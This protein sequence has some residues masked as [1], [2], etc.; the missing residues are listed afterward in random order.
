[1]MKS[2]MPHP[3][4]APRSIVVSLY[5]PTMAHLS[6]DELGSALS[7]ASLTPLPER[8]LSVRNVSL[9]Q[10][11]S[12]NN[13]KRKSDKPA[14]SKEDI[15]PSNKPAKSAAASAAA[16]PAPRVPVVRDDTGPLP[17]LAGNKNFEGCEK[18]GKYYITT[19]ISY[20]NGMPHIGHAYESLSMDVIA[21]WH[22]MYGRRVF[23]MTGTDEHGQKIANGAEAQGLQP[24]DICDK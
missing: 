21:R 3:I 18:R 14:S 11:S 10:V 24:I 5:F 20:S 1:M 17:E 22:R 6:Y 13:D 4:S 12:E 15:K 19:A 23:A 2:P 7:F 9:P 16:E 8:A